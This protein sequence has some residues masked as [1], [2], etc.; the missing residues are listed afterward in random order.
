MDRCADKDSDASSAHVPS[1][2][3][4]QVLLRVGG[5]AR[6]LLSAGFGRPRADRGAG[7]F[8]RSA[9]GRTAGTGLLE[10]SHRVSDAVR[11]RRWLQHV[12][13]PWLAPTRESLLH[14][15]LL[16][17]LPL[18]TMALMSLTLAFV[19]PLGIG[20]IRMVAGVA[21][22]RA[23]GCPRRGHVPETACCSILQR[24]S[25]GIGATSRRER[26]RE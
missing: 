9:K 6:F 1:C 18:Q 17:R 15:G 22:W 5:L 3:T 4:I 10:G 26:L 23:V 19:V 8:S 13:R 7:A 25:K 2:L 12:R 21:A 16:A 11:F 24:T 14:A 20:A